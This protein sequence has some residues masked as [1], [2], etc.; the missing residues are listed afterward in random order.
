M[1]DISTFDTRR[2]SCFVTS[3]EIFTCSELSLRTLLSGLNTSTLLRV[4]HSWS[5]RSWSRYG[6]DVQSSTAF[7]IFL[8]NF[9]AGCGEGNLWAARGGGDSVSPGAT[10][11]GRVM[12]PSCELPPGL[13]GPAHRFAGSASLV[14]DLTDWA[15]LSSSWR[16]ASC[17]VQIS[18]RHWCCICTSILCHLASSSLQSGIKGIVVS[19]VLLCCGVPRPDS[20][21]LAVLDC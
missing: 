1:P 16:A 19:I 8:G 11:G 15:R 10:R 3:L 7:A 4:F 13:G 20:R 18:W 2:S 6:V 5:G 21:A 12:G 9:S 14:T 17:M